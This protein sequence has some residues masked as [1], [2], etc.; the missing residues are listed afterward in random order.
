M[1][2]VD[3]A[4]IKEVTWHSIDEPYFRLTGL[5]WY[6]TEHKLNRLPE[7]SGLD[8]R[9]ELVSLGKNPTGVQLAFRSNTT[10]VYVKVTVANIDPVEHMPLTATAGFDLYVGDPGEQT[11]YMTCRWG[12][13][14]TDYCCH[15]F[16]SKEVKMRSFLL[17]F[18]LLKEVLS[19]EVG[20]CNEAVIEEPQEY[21][22]PGKIVF[23]GTS[24]THGLCVERPGLTYPNQISR[25][26]NQELVNLGFS[27]N[28]KGD[29]STAHALADIQDVSL[30]LLD[31]EAN[32]I[33]DTYM[34]TI[35]PIVK[36][37]R[38]SYPDVP[39][40]LLSRPPFATEIHQP[41][42]KAKRLEMVQ[43]QET[44]VRESH[45][46]NLYFKA[47]HELMD[48]DFSEYTVDSVHPNSLGSTKMAEGLTPV[49]TSILKLK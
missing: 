22:R 32:C 23:Y 43:K 20:L 12:T 31:Y 7:K 2:M 49:I 19:V 15:L 38:A 24:I 5:P 41:S 26:L 11:F 42:A 10:C 9:E 25:S 14:E 30:F 44:Y 4:S 3:S 40:L 47:W 1:A 21:A 33:D 45:D 37:L 17:N 13:E 48:D 8:F 6:A 18:P 34:Q 36:I 46:S 27:G 29:I 28:A 16:D 39:I 35:P